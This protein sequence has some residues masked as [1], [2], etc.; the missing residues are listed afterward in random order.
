MLLVFCTNSVLA[1][2]DFY[3]ILGVDR[4]AKTN[5]I[6]R[7]FRKL[8]QKYH[9]DKNPDDPQANEK[10]Q[11]MSVAYEVL[12]D[13][14]KRKQYDRCGE[15]CLKDQGGG[16]QD[17]FA[18]FFNFGF[19]FGGNGGRQNTDTPKGEDVVLKITVTLEEL[20]SGNFVD[21][22]RNKPIPKPAS[23]TRKCNCRR[24]MRTQSMGPGRFQMF[25]E[26]VCED[27]PNVKLMNEERTLEFEIQPGM[28]E[29]S[30]YRWVGEGEPHIDGDQGDLIIKILTLKHDQFERRG[31]DLYTNITISLTQALTGFTID[32]DHL[33][34]HKVPVVRDKVT[35]PGAKIK[36]KDEGMPNVDDN[37]KKG[38]LYVT[39]DVAFPK[40]ELDPDT[41]QAIKNLLGGV[42]DKPTVYNGLRGGR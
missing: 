1:G 29:N 33:D 4:R 10:F 21:I 8:A 30:E 23:G 37:T 16:R 15:D 38:D 40:G 36:K 5:E 18:D 24:E 19:G 27:C 34:G 35:F 32:I 14:D 26:T 39:F 6:K 25:E 42:D 41:K 2:R 7:A 13:E 17:P 28:R 20:Y 31:D 12:T 3:K 22:V 11:E 9:P